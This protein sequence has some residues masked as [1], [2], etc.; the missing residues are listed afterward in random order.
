VIFGVLLFLMSLG[1]DGLCHSLMIVLVLLG[2]SCS[3]IN[4]MSTL[5]T[6]KKLDENLSALNWLSLENDF[7]NY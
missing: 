5:V 4:P 2:F 7:F 1:H 6:P 3:N